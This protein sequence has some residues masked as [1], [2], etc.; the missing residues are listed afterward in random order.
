GAGECHL[1]GALAVDAQER[2]PGALGLAPLL[3]LLPQ[4][5]QA[6]PQ[7][8]PH[9]IGALVLRDHREH[10]LERPDL[11][12]KRLRLLELPLRLVI[13]GCQVGRHLCPLGWAMVDG[14]WAMVDGFFAS[15]CVRSSSFSASAEATACSSGIA[16]PSLH[17]AEKAA[18]PSARRAA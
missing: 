18:S 7:V 11:L 2:L 5:R 15:G 9:V 16:R 12:R 10:V 13:D 4:L 8:R 3:G 14:Q 6:P 1:A 17:A